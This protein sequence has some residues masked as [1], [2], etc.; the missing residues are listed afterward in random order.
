MASSCV[1]PMPHIVA[2]AAHRDDLGVAAGGEEQAIGK[3]RGVGQPR[4]ERVGFEMIDRDQR[5]AL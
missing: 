4:G 5:L 1:V 3:R 2:D